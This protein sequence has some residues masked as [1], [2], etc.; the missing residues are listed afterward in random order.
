MDYAARNKLEWLEDLSNQDVNFASRNR[1]R[2][3]ILP[4]ALQI[5]PGLYN[6]VKKR[7]N[8]KTPTEKRKKL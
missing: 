4:L 2:H 8:E 7:I 3:E 6:M 5:N 1:I